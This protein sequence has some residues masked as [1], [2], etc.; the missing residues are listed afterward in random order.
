MKWLFSILAVALL[1]FFWRSNDQGTNTD[2]AVTGDT[3]VEMTENAAGVVDENISLDMAE[4][5]GAIAEDITAKE[6][7]DE[8]AEFS[9]F[10]KELASGFSLKG[11]ANGIEKSLLDFVE[12]DTP[13]DKTTWFNFD[14]VTF[15][16]GS[17]EIDM[18]AS[19]DQLTNISEIMKIY[20]ATTL[21]IGGYTDNTGSEEANTR[22]SQ[23]R[24]EAVANALASLGVDPGRLDPE[25][26]GPQH[27]VASNDTEEGR[28]LN[29]R[30]AV[31]VKE[32]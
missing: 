13:V 23:Q 17:A 32:K 1:A 26:Y 15:R 31:R 18:N 12:S 4:N 28:A 8:V 7:M 29:R 14:R 5:A 25:G 2:V 19:S 9:A 11:K 21:K 6:G 24:A 20:P 16:T 10:T 22:I 30:I 27:P 3:G